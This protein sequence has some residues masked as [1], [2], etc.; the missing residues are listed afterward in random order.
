MDYWKVKD[1]FFQKTQH[2]HTHTHTYIFRKHLQPL[3]GRGILF[4]GYIAFCLFAVGKLQN[5]LGECTTGEL[6][7]VVTGCPLWLCH[8]DASLVQT[9]GCCKVL[10]VMTGAGAS[11]VDSKIPF[12]TSTCLHHF[13][14]G[15]AACFHVFFF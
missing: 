10:N 2:P 4:E 15:R 1:C 13:F 7:R 9:L 12:Q 8:G 6:C 3:A 14:F 11:T 5:F